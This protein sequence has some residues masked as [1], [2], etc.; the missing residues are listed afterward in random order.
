MQF[1]ANEGLQVSVVPKSGGEEMPIHNLS[2]GE[3]AITLM[4][5]LDLINQ[6][7]G[8]GIMI[9]DDLEK[10]DPGN[11]GAVVKFLENDTDSNFIVIACV[12]HKNITDVLPKKSIVK[13]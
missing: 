11:L 1:T 7:S 12:A 4:L 9:I 8:M 10:L 3:R 6:V 2:T 5:L 13:L